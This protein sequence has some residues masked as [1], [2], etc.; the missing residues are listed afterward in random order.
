MV[1]CSVAGCDRQ[2]HAQGFCKRHYGRWYRHG[3]PLA[4]GQHHEVRQPICTV[5]GCERPHACGGFCQN[6]YMQKRRNND[7]YRQWKRA[8][9]KRPH[10]RESANQRLRKRYANDPAYRAKVLEAQ[11]KRASR[12]LRQRPQA[13]QKEW[14]RMVHRHRGLCAYCQQAPGTTLEHVI[15]RSRGGG[16]TIGNLFPVCG[17]CNA[18]KCDLLLVE[19]KR[20]CG[21]YLPHHLKLAYEAGVQAEREY[22]IAGACH[23]IRESNPRFGEACDDRR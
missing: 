6:H 17:S 16:D 8:Y 19:W 5:E 20:W 13:F 12:T 21:D 14:R 11:T 15:P 3:D 22:R 4:G 7:E 9:N 2:N 18:S 10:V 1:I 23:A